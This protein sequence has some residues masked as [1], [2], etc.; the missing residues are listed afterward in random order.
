MLIRAVK[1]LPLLSMLLQA[2]PAQDPAAAARK[3]LDLFLAGKYPE[4]L[5]GSTPDVQKSLPVAELTKL[6]ATVKGYGAVEKI[7]DPAT[8]KA[9]P[10]SVVTL[11]VKFANQNINYRF[12]INSSG[13][14]GG[15]FQ[16][17]GAVDW[18]HPDYS[19]PDSFK[20]RAVT[21]GEGEWKLP[22]TLTVPNGSGPFPGVVLV[23][24]SGPNDRDETVGGIKMFKDLAEGL[25]SRGIAVLRYEK[26]TKQY[27]ARVSA[28]KN[29]TVEEETVEDAVKAAA[30]LRTQPEIDG[31]KVYILG[32][33]LGGYLLPRIVEQDAGLAG[34][35]I[36]AGNVRPLEDLLVEQMQYL[37]AKGTQ[38]EN[39]KT[40]QAKVKKLE[41][42]DEE[43]PSFGGVPPSY[44]LDLKGYDPAAAAKKLSIPILVL[45]GERDYQVTMTEFNLWKTALNGQKGVVL[46]SYPAL[47]FLFV[48]GEGK[49]L[50]AEYNKPGHVAP[51]VIDDIVAF[52]GK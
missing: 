38:L 37:G 13:L 36:M 47:N 23:H 45:Q 6:G 44:W 3:A 9:G 40:I 27:G 17:P 33:S 46:K 19:K 51:Q 31:K 20:E 48:A 22:G 15:F 1:L 25:A 35:I 8:T 12:L 50:P 42:G 10:N 16:L 7:G 2:Q 11:P 39:A 41:S 24:G 28:I 29:F 4:F 14:V 21:V 49:S 18:K 30:L 34:V 32:H 5:E 26:R 52:I 43:S